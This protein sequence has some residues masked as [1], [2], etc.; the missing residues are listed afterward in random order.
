MCLKDPKR[1][2]IG[3]LETIIENDQKAQKEYSGD[4]KTQYANS[5]RKGS[6]FVQSEMPYYTYAEYEENAIGTD[7]DDE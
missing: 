1:N 3:Y 5:Q 7:M 4:G 2:R 6:Y